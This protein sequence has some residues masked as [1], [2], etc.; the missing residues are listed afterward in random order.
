MRQGL[1]K[2]SSE[3]LGGFAGR[4]AWEP[5]GEAKPDATEAG[6]QDGGAEHSCSSIN[7][8]FREIKRFKLLNSVEE[9]S[10]AGRIA[11]GDAEA[12]KQMI[13]S[14]LRLVVNI[15][16]RYVNRGLQLQDLIDEGNIGLIK[17]VERFKADMGCRFS[18]YAT[19]WIRQTVERALANKG[20][21]IRLP[22]HIVTDM[23]RVEKASREF[24]VLSNRE[25]SSNEVSEKTGLSGRY[26]KKLET[27]SKRTMSLESRAGHDEAD[28]SLLDSIE[29]ERTPVPVEYVEEA[30][31]AER[32]TSWLKMLNE[33][34]MR[35]ISLRFGIGDFAPRTLETIGREF[36]VTR[37]RVRQIEEKALAK[38]RAIAREN[39][40][41]SADL[42]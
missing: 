40:T 23:S 24:R 14:N 15:A 27:I 33:N 4:T 2:Q 9:R 8:Y 12:R 26:V 25:P 7:I 10:L 5:Y 34:E 38:L 19:Y 39:E 6:V 30:R 41:G 21:M 17:A 3:A 16:K 11:I 31:R 36:G 22:I 42:L 29:D 20:S 13:E 18:T 37:E 28:L 1:R 35:I 32:V